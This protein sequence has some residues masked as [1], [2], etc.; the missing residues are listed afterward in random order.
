MMSLGA[1]QRRGDLQMRD[2]IAAPAASLVDRNFGDPAWMESPKPNDHACLIYDDRAEFISVAVAFLR[3]GLR[4]HQRLVY[5]GDEEL[6]TLARE[7]SALGDVDALIEGGVLI[8]CPLAGFC[9]PHAGVVPE[10]QLAKCE[11]LMYDALRDGFVGV[12]FATDVT[13][14]AAVPLSWTNHVRWEQL[15]DSAMDGQPVSALCAY[16]ARVVDRSA[17]AALS[18]VHPL[19]SGGGAHFGLYW[20]NGRLALE[21]ELDAYELPTLRACLDVNELGGDVH[22]DGSSL[23]FL[24]GASCAELARIGRSLRLQ[25]RRLVVHGGPS[26]LLR[27]QDILGF[28]DDFVV[29]IG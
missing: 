23:R 18:C 21:G 3:A 2:R 20:R 28:C 15:V 22:I 6:P 11:R 9:D 5:I 10:E 29:E 4:L 17:A 12:R 1:S 16:S 27:L 13:A 8:L 26:T 25:D 19:R 7:V 14:L 24:D